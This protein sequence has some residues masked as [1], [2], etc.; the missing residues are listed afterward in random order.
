[1]TKST[2]VRRGQ[3]SRRTVRMSDKEWADGHAKAQ[4][5]GRTLTDVLRGLLAGYLVDDAAGLGYGV[6]YRAVPRNADEK[7]AVDGIAGPFEDIRRLYP[8]KHWHLE[9]RTVS[10]YKPASRR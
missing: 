9:E 2:A 6:E 10:P 7:L 4:S 5:Q 1:M 3:L 8:A